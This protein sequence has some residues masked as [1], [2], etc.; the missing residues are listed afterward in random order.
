MHNYSRE[1]DLRS[2]TEKHSLI[3]G[4]ILKWYEGHKRDLPWRH[5]RDPYLI[6]VSEVILQQT[7]VQQGLPYYQIFTRTYPDIASLAAADEKEVLSLWQG[8]GYYSRAR[9]ML[10]AAHQVMDEMKG[11]FPTAYSDLLRLKGVG[12]YTA[13]A[14]AS[15]AASEQVAVVDGNVLRV[16]SRLAGIDGDPGRKSFVKIIRSWMEKAMQAGEPGTFNQAVMEFGALQCTPLKP[17]CRECPLQKHCTAYSE[18]RVDALPPRPK[19]KAPRERHL[20]FLRLTSEKEDGYYVFR[21]ARGIWKGLYLLPYL[22]SPERLPASELPALLSRE[23]NLFPQSYHIEGAATDMVHILT[24]QR[25]LGRFFHLR[26][27]DPFTH[28]LFPNL[29]FVHPAEAASVPMPRLMH[30]YLGISDQ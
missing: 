1:Y 3:A 29:V 16:V 8:L 19:R 7:R 22:E 2:V 9:N 6:W 18:N 5:T 20:N 27:Q 10:Q 17:E 11:A 24:H 30:K 23:L 25:I 14:V 12:E 13:A 4:L 28:T 21:Q 26:M 15:I